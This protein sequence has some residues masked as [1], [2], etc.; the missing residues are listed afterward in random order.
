M[1]ISPPFLLPIV[2]QDKKS[3]S[4]KQADDE[5]TEAAM[6]P[7]ASRLV[8][9]TGA[10]EGAFP[11]SNHLMWHNGVHLQAPD[12]GD[13]ILPLHAIAD[14]EILF[15]NRP[16]PH[17]ADPLEGLNYDEGW[18]DNGCIILKHMTE[19]GAAGDRPVSVTYYS[20]Y[21]HIEK[22][23]GG[24]AEG[25]K[26]YRKDVLGGAGRVYGHS[27]Q[28]HFEI[29]SDADNLK[30][31]IGRHPTWQ[32]PQHPPAKDGRTDSVFG[33]LYVYLPAATPTSNT[34]PADHL[35]HDTG[36]TLGAA[37]WIK[38]DYGDGGST[39]GA[40]VL[41]SYSAT[42]QPGNT[43]TDNDAEYNLYKD[44]TDRHSTVI[45]AH[46]HAQSS[47]SGWYE[48]L[49]FGR[50][51]GRSD[52]DKDPLPDNA[53]HWRKIKTIA[54]NEVWAD[55]NAP[56][57]YKFSDADFLPQF[58]WNCYDDDIADKDQ[59]C[60]SLK[61]KALIRT[62]GDQPDPDRNKDDVK[63]SR[64][65]GDKD[66][67]RAL[68]RTICK[69]PNEWDRSTISQRYGWLNEMEYG[70]KDRLDDWKRFENH[71]KAIS[72]DK[73]PQEYLNAQWHFHPTEFIKHFRKCRW[74]NEDELK[75]I[76]PG[77]SSANRTK[78]RIPVSRSIR[79]YLITTPLRMAHFLGQAA[80]ETNQF[81]WM[82]ELY[83][84][85]AYDYFRHYAKASN[86]KGWL[87]NVEWNDGGTYRGRG[88]K[89]LT[90]R[91]NYALYWVYKGWL[92]SSSFSDDWWKNT[93]WWGLS[94]NSIPPAMLATLPIQNDQIVVQL[95][96]Q[97]RPPIIVNPD[98]VNTELEASIDT[99][100]WFWARNTLLIAADSDDVAAMTRKI[101]GDAAS[102]GV[103]TSWPVSAHFTERT[104]QTSRIKKLLGE[105]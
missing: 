46:P 21:M 35:R 3:T 82:S 49:R 85:S 94:G 98:R 75:Q 80:V 14:G 58:G 16:T 76:Y 33:N 78:Y 100:G 51:L 62:Q 32:D 40:C 77:A 79:K 31:I 55:L 99:A 37:Q 81:L 12:L 26:V 72:F 57:S 104:E 65:L 1:I 9:G 105:I 66:V 6:P 95:K 89:Q 97:M 11:V 64:R 17:S 39:P 19:I 74:L 4:K 59:R 54:G 86:F 23:I 47:P 87:G 44:A 43:R 103:T 30:K 22:F 91:A 25:K 88:F 56:G 36:S 38:L 8:G 5:R 67:A 83:S 63:L 90:G 69:F 53:A 50:N 68:R 27:K 96:E 45:K 93:G 18:T 34:A 73:L 7:S 28:V 10:E 41:T 29:C 60:D 15:L 84:G 71:L 52:T 101:R 2:G 20:V 42:G 61:L 102:V 24:L 92:Q 70:F 13:R 48:L